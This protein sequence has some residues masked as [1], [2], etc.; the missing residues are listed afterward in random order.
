MVGFTHEQKCT[1]G[2][3]DARIFALS[4]HP[5]LYKSMGPTRHNGWRPSSS[6]NPNS[7][8]PPSP[9]AQS[10]VRR[11]V[12]ASGD[13]SRACVCRASSAG[14]PPPPPT[15]RA[16]PSHIFARAR[17]REPLPRVCAAANLGRA[18][19]RQLTGIR[20]EVRKARLHHPQPHLVVDP[21][22]W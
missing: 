19:S 20:R 9:E 2:S 8:H 17:D 1:D 12:A 16:S 15:V 22:L 18:P 3:T 5:T 21:S 14:P 6:P 7:S 13:P 11:R 10:P 4:I